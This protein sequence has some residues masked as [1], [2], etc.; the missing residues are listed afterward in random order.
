AGPPEDLVT[1]KETSRFGVVAWNKPSSLNGI[2]YG[3]SLRILNDSRCI[4]EVLWKCIDCPGA[5]P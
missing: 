5:F 4:R 1:K 3:Y 2:L